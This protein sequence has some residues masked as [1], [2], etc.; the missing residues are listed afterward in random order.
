MFRFKLKQAKTQTPSLFLCAS[1][2]LCLK[3]FSVPRGFKGLCLAIQGFRVKAGEIMV[4]GSGCH[5]TAHGTC[6]Q[7]LRNPVIAG[8]GGG[9]GVALVPIGRGGSVEGLLSVA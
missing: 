6:I 5:V 8:V 1:A 4:S 2:D 9:G 3:K 7:L